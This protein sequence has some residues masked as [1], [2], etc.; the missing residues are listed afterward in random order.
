[1][2]KIISL[3]LSV[4]MAFSCAFMLSSC[5]SDG[6]VTINV[7]NWG[8]YIADGT[9]GTPDVIEQFTKETGIRVNYTF[10][11]SNETLYSKLKAGGVSYDVI[12]PSDYMI[13]KMIDEDMLAELDFANIPNYELIDERFKDGEF[14]SYDPECK[15]SVPYTWGRTGLVYNTKYVTAEEASS[16][17]VLWNKK[18]KGKTLMFDNNRD[19][20]GVAELLLGKSLNTSDEDELKEVADKLKEQR[21]SVDP[22]YVMD[23]TFDNMASEEAYVAPYYLGDCLTMQGDNPDLGVTVPKEGCNLF[24]DAMCVPKTS[25]YKAEAE[26]FINFMCGTDVAYANIEYI[27]YSSPQVE[28]AEQHKKYLTE[29]FD[30]ETAALIYPDDLSGG[31]IYLTLDNETYQTMTNLWIDIRK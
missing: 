22:V 21:E 25:R 23:Q 17:G 4:I 26:Q 13:G 16:W 28:A 1:M 7:Y 20:F 10:F 19:A 11:T 27:Q 2:K 6:T 5:N 18:F 31:E 24:V 29:N 15:Y 30:A 8:E 3:S 12:I 14:T 9:D